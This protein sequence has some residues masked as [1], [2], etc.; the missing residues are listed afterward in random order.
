[1]ER[2]GKNGCEDI[3]E[4]LLSSMY[5]ISPAEAFEKVGTLSGELCLRQGG[6]CNFPERNKEVVKESGA[7]VMVPSILLLITVSILSILV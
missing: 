1:M 7:E 6:L 4:E 5:E 3:T 2:L